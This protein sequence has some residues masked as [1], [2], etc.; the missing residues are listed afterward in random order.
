MLKAHKFRNK[1]C[2]C[3]LMP[4]KYK[5]ASGHVVTTDLSII[6]NTRLRTHMKAGTT[7]RGSYLECEQDSDSD[8]SQPLEIKLL[9]AGIKS[10]IKKS[11]Q[12][13][14]LPEGFYNEWRRLLMEKLTERYRQ[15]VARYVE[16]QMNERT[17][18]DEAV[19]CL[20][21]IQRDYAI[22]SADKA[23]NTYVIHCKP[24]LSKQ[25]L[26]ETETTDT[27][28]RAIRDDGTRRWNYRRLL[29]QIGDLLKQRDLQRSR[30]IHLIQPCPKYLKRFY[31]IKSCRH[32]EWS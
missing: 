17:L 29:M 32:L 1:G 30:L 12:L 14:D 18:D 31:S 4:N 19:D 5:D 11:S 21:V 2:Q 3:H 28:K 20:R 26:Q 23:K 27:Y 10:Y 16:Q 13:N 9:D 8:D 24:W 6:P 15:T 25:V 7:F 22:L